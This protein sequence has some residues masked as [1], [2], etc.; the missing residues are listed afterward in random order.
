M[1]KAQDGGTAGDITV[2]LRAWGAGDEEAFGQLAPLLYAE[3]KK[4]AR[5]YMTQERRDHTLQPTALV[6][7][8]FLRLMKAQGLAL[9]DRVHF[10]ALA[11]RVMRRILVSHAVQRQRGKR[12]AGAK[13]IPLDDDLAIASPASPEEILELNRALEELARV[14]A[15]KAQMVELHFFGGL[16][17]AETATVLQLSERTIR[18]DWVFVKAWL[19]RE[20][21]PATGK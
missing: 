20:M 15:R 11:A 8:A 18:R 7:E 4:I 6:N 9:Q 1:V 14:D 2:L 10:L 16:S 5:H 12:G 19:A 13:N 21:G 3:L 17:F